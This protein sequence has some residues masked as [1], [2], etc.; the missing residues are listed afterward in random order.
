MR[1]AQ[2]RLRWAVIWGRDFEKVEAT[3]SW[4]EPVDSC[5]FD[6]VSACR[7]PQ[8]ARIGSSQLRYH[9]AGARKRARHD[10][11]APYVACPLADAPVRKDRLIATALPRRRRSQA[12][13]PRFCSTLRGVSACGRPSSQGSAHR[14]CATTAQAL[15]S[16][17]ATIL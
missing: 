12:S 3:L 13:T 1:G 6:S 11:V 9:G 7:T 5:R 4:P 8:F 2:R 15:A 14:N 16:E 17:H 10:F